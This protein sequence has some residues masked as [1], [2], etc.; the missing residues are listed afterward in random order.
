M[1]HGFKMNYCFKYRFTVIEWR[2]SAYSIH[3][4]TR[5]VDQTAQVKKERGA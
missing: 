3:Q 2:N 4:S 5:G 1:N